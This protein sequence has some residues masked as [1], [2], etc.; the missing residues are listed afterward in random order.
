MRIVLL[1]AAACL[2]FGVGSVLGAASGV[3]DKAKDASGQIKAATAAGCEKPDKVV[4]ISFSKTKYPHIRAHALR[5][6]HEGWPS[7]LVLD[8]KGTVQRREKALAGRPKKSGYDLDEYPPA[9]GRESWP[10]DVEPVQSH[11]NRS[12]GSVMATKLRRLCDGSRFR[13]V[14]S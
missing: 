14:W 10:A 4:D 3:L 8:R 13:Y 5:A 6:I 7:V 9:V 11:E 12:H 2:I 1:I